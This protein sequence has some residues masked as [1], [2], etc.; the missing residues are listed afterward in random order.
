MTVGAVLSDAT[1]LM[2]Q[3][4]KRPQDPEGA[5]F[6]PIR[7]VKRVTFEPSARYIISRWKFSRLDRPIGR[8]AKKNVVSEGTRN[9]AILNLTA[10]YFVNFPASLYS[11]FLL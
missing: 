8:V 5:N 9:L 11:D 6:I 3:E 1:S 7:Y 2:C 4:G 10:K